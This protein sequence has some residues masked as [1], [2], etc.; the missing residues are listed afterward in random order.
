[1]SDIGTDARLERGSQEQ[2]TLQVLEAPD[3]FT[4]PDERAEVDA[5]FRELLGDDELV[6]TAPAPGRALDLDNPASARFFSQDTHPGL[7]HWRQMHVP[8]AAALLPLQRP[9]AGRLADG[10]PLND[11]E[12]RIFRSSLDAVGV[13]SRAWVMSRLLLADGPGPHPGPAA[14]RWL[15]LACG[16]AVPVYEAASL[17]RW[18]GVQVC[19]DLA[20]H[21]RGALALAARLAAEYGLSPTY[22]RLN[23]LTADGLAD[24]LPRQAYDV[25]D[26]LGLFEYLDEQDS[27]VRYPRLV[28]GRERRLAGA[29]TFLRN[30]YELVRPGGVLVM[31]NMLD[32]HPQLA[33]TLGVVQWP[34]LR[35]RSPEQVRSIVVR[36]GIPASQMQAFAAEDG[37]YGVYVLAKDEAFAS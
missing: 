8:S 27:V 18:R 10:T 13:R 11:S 37:V 1:M 7:R 14:Q 15:S 2:V 35:P 21:D 29:V 28:S 36:A 22:H 30:A 17:L 24:R 25:V 6:A 16:A 34:Y 19:L 31:S 26:V 4:R 5:Y 33:V 23:V 20:D 32:T 9:L 3:P 12:Q